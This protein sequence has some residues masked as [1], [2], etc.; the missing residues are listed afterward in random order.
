M[1]W[2][3]RISL[4]FLLLLLLVV[5]LFAFVTMTNGGMQRMFSLGQSYMTEDLKVGG[6]EGKLIG[7]GSISQLEYSSAGTEVMVDSIEYDWHPK[8]LFSRKLSV[9]NLNVSG[10]TVHLPETEPGSEPEAKEPFQLKDLK[11]PFAIEAKNLSITDVS[12]YQPGAEEPLVI[13]E[14]L[15][16]A[17]GEDDAIRLLELR[18]SSP[19]GN[20][21]LGGTLNT[22]GDWPLALENEWT[23]NHNQFGVFTGG[24]SMT[25]D[26][27]KMRVVHK[28][29]GLIDVEVDAEVFDVTGALSWD[30]NI[31]ARSADLVDVSAGLEG[32]PLDVDVNTKGSME[33]FFAEGRIASEH[34]Q[35]GPAATEFKFSGNLEQLVFE[36]SSVV[37]EQSP[38]KL[39]Y[40]GAVDLKTLEAD[41][42]IGWTDLEYP[43]VADP[44]LALSPQGTLKFTG[45][46]ENYKV[47]MNSTVQQEQTGDLAIVLVAS[48]TPDKVTV[49][50]LTVDGPPTSIYSVGVIDL[51]TREVDI[52]GNWKDVRWPLIGDE[53]LV[54]SEKADFSVKGTLDDY[55]LEAELAVE[56]KDIP[57]GDWKISTRGNT[58]SLSDLSVTGKVLEGE[59][60]AS[61]SVVFIPKPEWDLAVKANGLN[62]GVQWPDH[63]G[64]I[65]FSTTTKGSITDNGFL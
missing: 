53:E 58:E 63:E 20:L 17:G 3:K 8:Q 4:L 36:D 7:P 45:S 2:V 44:K 46:A 43:L 18:A 40:A 34:E 59:V 16:R 32:I 62:P 23:F 30:G 25:G 21:Q 61:G 64:D 52:K 49:N 1:I 37:F 19:L 47:Q 35:S 33:K 9:E 39:T 29:E 11:I 12:I 38:A 60:D 56:G 51:K 24:G 6:V 50:T 41:M 57:A 65:S 28:V 26:L 54:R 5:A 55:Q 10:V 14:I 22:S 13:D 48:G 27:K 42:D 31:K 15:L